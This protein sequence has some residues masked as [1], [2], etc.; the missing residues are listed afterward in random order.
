MRDHRGIIFAS[1]YTIIKKQ[2]GW[3]LF[4]RAK[5]MPCHWSKQ[6]LFWPYISFGTKKKFSDGGGWKVTLVTVCVHFWTFRYTDTK[7]TKSFKI[8]IMYTYVI[9]MDCINLLPCGQ[10]SVKFS[11]RKIYFNCLQT[12]SDIAYC[13]GS[14]EDNLY[15]SIK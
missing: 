6:V 8:C 5:S 1:L 13:H 15:I 9:M 12:T 2:N 3:Y 14:G 11:Q 7:L 4:I 10:N